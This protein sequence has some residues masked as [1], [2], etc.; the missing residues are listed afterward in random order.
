LPVVGGG[1]LL[2]W[3]LCP[4]TWPFSPPD[5]CDPGDAELGDAELE[6]ARPPGVASAQNAGMLATPPAAVAS[7]WKA[8]ELALLPLVAPWPDAKAVHS[9]NFAGPVASGPGLPDGVGVFAGVGSAAA[10]AIV[11]R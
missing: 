2:D 8:V 5:G 11:D 4:V 1:P 10:G 6:C 3:L 7:A 9:P